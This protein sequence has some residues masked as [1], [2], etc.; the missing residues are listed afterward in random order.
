MKSEKVGFQL[1]EALK[2]PYFLLENDS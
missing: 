2:Y 1:Q